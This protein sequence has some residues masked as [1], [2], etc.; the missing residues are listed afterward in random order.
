MRNTLHSRVN[1]ICMR[2]NFNIVKFLFDNNYKT[3]VK[4]GFFEN[5]PKGTN[6]ILDLLWTCLSKAE[7][8]ENVQ[9]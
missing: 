6:G 9:V 7:S 4:K 2:K 1:R 5:V 8:I 3:V